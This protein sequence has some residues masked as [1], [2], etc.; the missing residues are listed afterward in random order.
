[1]IQ[2][3]QYMYIIPCTYVPRSYSY[4]V[5]VHGRRYMSY[6]VYTCTGTQYHVQVQGTMY[7]VELCTLY[8][9]LYMYIVPCTCTRYDVHIQGYL[10]RPL[11]VDVHRTCT[12]M[13]IL[14]VLCM[15][16]CTYVQV[17]TST[18]C[19]HTCTPVQSQTRIVPVLR[20]C[21]AWSKKQLCSVCPNIPESKRRPHPHFSFDHS[22]TVSYLC[23]KSH[24]PP[25]KPYK[26]RFLGQHPYNN[27][28][29][30]SDIYA[31]YVGNLV[32]YCTLHSF[33]KY[34]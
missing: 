13:H 26:P 32:I 5:Q 3:T 29:K 24:S 19:T 30:L 28:N 15:Y 4:K 20:C 6:I 8:I 18:Q 12:Y 1:M 10:V 23:R 33:M 22:L 31:Q 27:A 2:G 21:F 11:H 9:S 7:I 17:R 16:I 14:Q 25:E 34:T